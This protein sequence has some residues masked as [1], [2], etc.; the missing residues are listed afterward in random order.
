LSYREEG[1]LATREERTVTSLPTSFLL[2]P[3]MADFGLSVAGFAMAEGDAEFK[4]A[5]PALL[6]SIVAVR[7]AFDAA[8]SEFR[9]FDTSVEQL[10]DGSF[11]DLLDRFAALEGAFANGANQVRRLLSPRFQS[12]LVAFGEGRV[13]KEASTFANDI[14]QDYIPTIRRLR[15]VGIRSIFRRAE[16]RGACGAALDPDFEERFMSGSPEEADSWQETAYLM[17]HSENL[18]RL[19][20][21]RGSPAQDRTE[22]YIQFV[23]SCRPSP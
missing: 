1:E 2:G 22:E 9:N 14:H 17:G 4:I 19:I 6:K 15:M 21:S 11:A 10:H 7:A 12:V 3:E 13:T 16:A 18:I 5:V 8:R 23:E 20:A